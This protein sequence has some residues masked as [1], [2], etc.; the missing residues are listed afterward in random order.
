MRI[1]VFMTPCFLA[2]GRHLKVPMIG[3]IP[4]IFFDWLNEFSGN[5]NNPSFVPTLFSAFEQQMNFKERVLN[6]LMMYWISTQFHYYTSFQVEYVKKH[7]GMQDVSIIDFYSDISL[8]L[9]NSHPSLQGVQPFTHNII[10]VAG[11][12]IKDKDDPLSPVRLSKLASSIIR[13]MWNDLAARS[14]CNETIYRYRP[15]KMQCSI[16]LL[17]V[18]LEREMSGDEIDEKRSLLRARCIRFAKYIG[19]NWQN[20]EMTDGQQESLFCGQK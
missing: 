20:V 6:F 17:F 16:C 4:S 13:N 7:F 5:P 10:E 3:I 2:F 15:C 1:Q 14:G 11:L 9:T 12:H 19:S 8:Y 18:R